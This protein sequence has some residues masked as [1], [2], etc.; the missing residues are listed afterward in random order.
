MV[1][2]TQTEQR[3]ETIQRQLSKQGF[4]VKYAHY[5]NRPKLE[6]YINPELFIYVAECVNSSGTEVHSCT[7]HNFTLLEVFT[8]QLIGGPVNFINR[9]RE[10]SCYSSTQMALP[11]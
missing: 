10:Q 8:E 1:L 4:Q 9:L 3:L 2:T 5:N 11:M 6:V 7:K